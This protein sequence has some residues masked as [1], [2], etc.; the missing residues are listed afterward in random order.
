MVDSPC[1]VISQSIT[2]IMT[3]S[4][5]DSDLGQVQESSDAVLIRV[6]KHEVDMILERY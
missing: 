4:P 3:D 6:S 2:M 1:H 5:V